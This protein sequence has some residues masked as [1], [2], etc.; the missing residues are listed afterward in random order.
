MKFIPENP[1]RTLKVENYTVY[2]YE[3]N[4]KYLA[5]GYKNRKQ[6]F[7]YRYMSAAQRESSINEK[8]EYYK[9]EAQWEKE[10]LEK[11][12]KEFEAFNAELKEGTVVAYSWGWEQTNYQFYQVVGRKGKSTVILRELNVERGPEDGFMTALVTPKVGSFR[13]ENLVERRL[14]QKYGSYL[15]MEHGVAKIWEGKSER[16]TWYA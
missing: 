1:S 6:L 11:T 2:E 12:V 13:N 7:H 15:K 10:R 9:K 4:G 3:N 5:V 8:V 16:I 14:N